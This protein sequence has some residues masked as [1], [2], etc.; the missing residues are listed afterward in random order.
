[1]NTDKNLKPAAPALVLTVQV[2]QQLAAYVHSVE[3]EISGLGTITRYTPNE[4]QARDLYLLQQTCTAASTELDPDAVATLIYNYVQSGDDPG[5]I[6]LWWHSHY[7]MDVSWSPTDENTIRNFA[8]KGKWMISLVTNLAGD[9]LARLDMFDPTHVT[10]PLPVKIDIGSDI[11]AAKYAII[12]AEQKVNVVQPLPV[13]IGGRW[14]RRGWRTAGSNPYLINPEK[15]RD[16]IHDE[17]QFGLSNPPKA[18]DSDQFD[19]WRP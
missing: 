5:K 19:N 13:D 4:F 16:L 12:E 10:L 7:S 9:Y 18:T 11:V 6:R 17:D 2:A 3:A 1:M 15:L 14:Q 8:G